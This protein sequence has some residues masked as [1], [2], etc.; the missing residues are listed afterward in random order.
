MPD[1]KTASGDAAPTSD[2]KE[3]AATPKT[4]PPPE[5]KAISGSRRTFVKSAVIGGAAAA[6]VGAAWTFLSPT[7]RPSLL[8]LTPYGSFVIWFDGQGGLY[9]RRNV[10]TGEEEASNADGGRV[11]QDA[12]SALNTPAGGEIWLASNVNLPSSVITIDRSNISL[13]ALRGP[14][15]RQWASPVPHVQKIRYTGDVNGG[16]LQ[17]F[18]C[19]EVLFDGA[20]N[21]QMIACRDLSM[22]VTGN[23]NEQGLRFTGS[24]GYIQYIQID[25]LKTILSGPSP[26]AI[27]FA[28]SN[29]GTGHIIFTGITMAEREYDATGAPVVIKVATGAQTGT[30]IQF[31]Y[32]SAVDLGDPQRTTG[33]GLRPILM[34]SQSA[35]ERGLRQ[36]RIQRLFFEQHYA[37]EHTIVTIEPAAVGGACWFALTIDDL[38]ISDATGGTVNLID[39]Q[40][41]SWMSR[42]QFLRIAS[43]SKAG[44]GTVLL[45]KPGLHEHFRM[46]LGEFSGVTPFGKLAT[47]FTAGAPTSFVGPGGTS[48]TPSA[49]ADYVVAV[50]PIV[51]SSD[52]P[53]ALKDAD[54]V[55]IEAAVPAGQARTVPIG[56]RV[57]FLSGT[58]SVYA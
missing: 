56:Y 39:N 3:T 42:E 44:V 14:P 55:A 15:P 11:V 25:N 31:E 24:A 36:M 8:P 19:R 5:E 35:P 23:P 40:N 38:V 2:S 49:T 33:D 32:L 7:L 50:T 26:T 37:P 34:Q 41:A 43:G 22:H 18:H 29:G 47:P 45:G 17:G 9:H 28:N 53:W 57:Q 58:P 6:A 54:G 1:E 27:E 21:Q 20:G 48:A 12:I 46:Y 16:L 4:P 30:P 13:I 52:Q 51:V 10:S